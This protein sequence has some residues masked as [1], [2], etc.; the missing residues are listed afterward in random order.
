MTIPVSMF[1]CSIA[2]NKEYPEDITGFYKP[3]FNGLAER[4]MLIAVLRQ[5]L[6]TLQ[7]PEM[8]GAIAV[9]LGQGANCFLADRISAMRDHSGLDLDLGGSTEH[10]TEYLNKLLDFHLVIDASNA[11]Q[12]GD[13][14]RAIGDGCYKFCKG[15]AQDY[16]E[17]EIKNPFR[18][19]LD[20]FKNIYYFDLEYFNMIGFLR[21]VEPN[22]DYFKR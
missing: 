4:V 6:T 2:V 9:G 19:D 11:E 3:L 18:Q 7:V 8:G 21:Q 1:T 16:L 14:N 10:V 15:K 13:V 20:D 5:I 12:D 17:K 22:P